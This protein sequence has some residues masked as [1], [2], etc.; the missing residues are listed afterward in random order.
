MSC[1]SSAKGAEDGCHPELAGVSEGA[2]SQQVAYL[3]K[4]GHVAV[5]PDPHDN[6]AKVVRLIER[7]RA[8]AL[9]A[10]VAQRD[11]GLPHYPPG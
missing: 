7:G 6:R 1:G 9:D 4:H 8:E 11:A 3:E 10:V 5:E 2:I